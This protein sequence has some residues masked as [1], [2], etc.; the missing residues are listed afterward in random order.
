MREVRVGDVAM[1]ECGRCH[2][3]WV[4]AAT[5]EHICASREAQAAVL[6]Q[7]S[8]GSAPPPRAGL[9]AEVKYR[10]C[11][12]CGTMMNRLNF[13]RL[14]GTIVDVCKG[15]GTFLDAGELHRIVSFIQQGGLDRARQRQ[16]DDLKE[17]ERRLNALRMRQ[18][19]QPGSVHIERSAGTWS[20]TADELFSLLDLLKPD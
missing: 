9:A 10:P 20:G 13:G 7:W 1:L 14:S 11:V 15:H 17:E 2:G 5:F 3:T 12:G 16:I 8:A 19:A 4:D 18:D 6:H